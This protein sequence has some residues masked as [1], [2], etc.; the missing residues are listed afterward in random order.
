MSEQGANQAKLN[1]ENRIF[2]YFFIFRIKSHNFAFGMV[3]TIMWTVG[4]CQDYYLRQFSH[5]KIKL[6]LRLLKFLQR[7]YLIRNH[8]YDP[9]N[10]HLQILKIKKITILPKS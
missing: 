4:E 5:P 2:I 10:I 8:V 3:F 7:L 9:Q 1:L 6:L